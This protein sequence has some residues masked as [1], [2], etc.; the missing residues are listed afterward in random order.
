MKRNSLIAGMFIFCVHGN[1]LSR[2]DDIAKTPPMGWNSWNLFQSNITEAKTKSVVDAFVTSGLKD[3][4]YQYIVVDDCWSNS[5]RDSSN[6]LVAQSAKFPSGMKSLA[7]YVHGKGLKFG[8]YASPTRVTCC[9]EAGSF[10]HETKDAETFAAWGVDYLKYDWCGVQSG[11]DNT[12]LTATDIIARYVTMR[13]ALKATN[14]PILYALCEK[15]QKSH[16]VPGTWSDTVG[17]MWRIGGDIGAIW[18]SITS[19]IDEDASLGADAGPAKGWN[20]PDMLE[21]GNGSLTEDEN[22]AHFSMWCILAAPLILGNDPSGM[23]SVIKD[24]VANKEAIAINQDSLGLQGARIKKTGDQEAWVKP[25]QNGDKAVALFNRGAANATMTVNWT[26]SLINWSASTKVAVRNIWA[27]KDSLGVTN[28][29]TI[30]VGSHAVVLLRL[31]SNGPGAENNNRGAAITTSKKNI[32]IQKTSRGVR[33][34]VPAAQAGA[35]AELLDIRG[36]RICTFRVNKDWNYLPNR[37]L[38]P[39]VFIV[40][41]SLFQRFFTI[42]ER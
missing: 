13:E 14:R 42:E 6:T 10:G 31:N 36:K 39:G 20:D 23:S 37:M 30:N 2:N 33:L 41:G 5:A 19:H 35:P 29:F 24:I 22:R 21:V 25:L 9:R 15:G 27:H 7:D 3:A 18:S 32:L 16:I 34:F 4:G 12:N 26:D 40:R 38:L 8:M 17:H 1:A 28:G 11:E